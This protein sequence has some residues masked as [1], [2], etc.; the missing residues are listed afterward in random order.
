MNKDVEPK[1]F[2]YTLCLHYCSAIMKNCLMHVHVIRVGAK[3][4]GIYTQVLIYV[5]G[6][7]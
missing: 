6:S 1:K 3:Y 4:F 2:V 7:T 5:Q